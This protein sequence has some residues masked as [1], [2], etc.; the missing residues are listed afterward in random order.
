[1]EH[2]SR[3]QNSGNNNAKENAAESFKLRCILTIILMVFALLFDVL[4][5]KPLGIE[6]KQIFQIL[7]ENAINKE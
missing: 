3:K 5:I 1:M 4:E 7:T 6:M 2:I